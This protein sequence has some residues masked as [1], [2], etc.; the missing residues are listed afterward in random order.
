MITIKNQEY[1][2]QIVTREVERGAINTVNASDVVKTLCDKYGPYSRE[3]MFCP[4]LSPAIYDRYIEVIRYDIKSVR[5]IHEP[6]ERVDSVNCLLWFQLGKRASKERQDA[7]EVLCCKCVRL[8]V[9]WT[10]RKEEVRMKVL[11]KSLNVK[12]HHLKHH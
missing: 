5:R 10:V 8:D 7:S 3:Y 6:F 1:I 4:G 11:P 9:T 12:K 2:V